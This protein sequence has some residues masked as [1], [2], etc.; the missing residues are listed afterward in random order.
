MSNDPRLSVAMKE[1]YSLWRSG[2]AELDEAIILVSM[3]DPTGERAKHIR[4]ALSG[5]SSFDA[6]I[7]EQE[8]READALKGAVPPEPG[9]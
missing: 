1:V 7:W 2:R 9:K 5:R 8:R 6:A 4:N 3:G